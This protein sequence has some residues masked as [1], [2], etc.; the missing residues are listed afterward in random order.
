MTAPDSATVPLARAVRRT[1]RLLCW[2]LAV[3][4]A[5]AALDVT[6]TPHIRWW[7]TLWVLPWCLACASAL[8]WALLRARQKSRSAPPP[9]EGFQGDWERAA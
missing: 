2:S 4:M 1:G 6:L 5:A 7:H 3:G 9:E 8:T